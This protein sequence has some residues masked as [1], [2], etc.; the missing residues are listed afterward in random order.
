VTLSKGGRL[1]SI[2][3]VSTFGDLEA[4]VTDMKTQAR[5]SLFSRIGNS[6]SPKNPGNSCLSEINGISVESPSASRRGSH[7]VSLDTRGG[8][9]SLLP[10]RPVKTTTVFDDL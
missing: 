6:G 1:A 10:V 8:D 4:L 5:A 9:R 2:G 7:T 3:I